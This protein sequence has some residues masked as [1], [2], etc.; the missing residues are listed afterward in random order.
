M[1]DGTLEKGREALATAITD[2]SACTDC[3]KFRDEGALGDAP[4]LTSYGSREWLIG[5]IRDP[6]HEQYYQG[7]ND[8]MPAFGQTG[9]GPTKQPLLSAAD[10]ELLA[11]WIRGEPLD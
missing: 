3:H 4:D 11:K 2:G 8:R 10:I 1:D 7:N 9:A 6:D 5:M